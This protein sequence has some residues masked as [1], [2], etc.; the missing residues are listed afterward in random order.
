MTKYKVT[1]TSIDPADE[2][3][4][5]EFSTEVAARNSTEAVAA[6]KLLLAEVKPGLNPPITWAWSSYKI[7]T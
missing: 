7:C 5:V 6:A 2:S 4:D 3:K 1:L